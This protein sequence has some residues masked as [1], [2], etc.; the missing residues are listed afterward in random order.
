MKSYFEKYVKYDK[1]KGGLIWS[2]NLGFKIKEGDSVGFLTE[3][4]YV[5]FG[6]QGKQYMVHR[7]VWCLHFGDMPNLQIDHKDRDKTNN[8]IENLRVVS[9]SENAQNHI[10]VRKNN[11]SS[12]FLGVSFDKNM[13]KF[14][15][16][17]VLN[18]KQELIGYFEDEKEASDAYLKRKKEIHSSFIKERVK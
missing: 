8:R 14:R 13:K 5:R 16:T 2:C 10:K 9:N 3:K 15:A 12:K 17:I 7:V 4:G 1:E 6:L 18:G 11:K